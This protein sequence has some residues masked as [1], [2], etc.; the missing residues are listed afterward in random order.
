MTS[1]G[2]E[3]INVE[4]P[5]A[6]SELFRPHRYKVFYGGRGSAKSHSI[7]TALILQGYEQKLRILCAREYMMS[8]ADSVHRLLCDKIYELKLHNF[9]TITKTSIVGA[10]GTNFMFKGL[11]MSPQEIK[12]TEA[13]DRC[14]LEESQNVSNYSFEILI[15]TIRKENSEIWMSFNPNSIED[16]VYSRFVLNPPPDTY[17]RRVNF[18]ENPFFP[19]V[20]KKE[21]AHSQSTDLEA[22]SH[23]WL[24]E[25]RK[26]AE[27]VIFN[28]RIQ[29]REFTAPD[30]AR[31]YFGAD[32]GY[33]SDP[34]CIVRCFIDDAENDLYIDYESLAYG[35]EID[36]LYS[37]FTKVPGAKDWPIF[38]DC[39]RPETISYL[40][41]SGLAIKP[42][43]KWPGSIEDGL[44]HLKGYKN[45]FVHPRCKHTLEEFK[46][47]SY[48]VDT[49]TQE[50]LPI[51]IDKHNHIIDAL[52]YALCKEMQSRGSP[53]Q[54]TK[55]GNRL[56]PGGVA[57][58]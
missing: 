41:R 25:P 20:L 44:A 58:K 17:V 32:F 24:G 49:K 15:P 14:W 35:A 26:I 22:Y 31:Y 42:C 27:S 47:Y 52:R 54:W 39:A 33:S 10:N 56:N 3:I 1:A 9:Y 11:H 4:I 40:R 50:V 34:S 28:K 16:P 46:L 53:G 30:K 21:A 45:I 43:D 7:A 48:K 37:L 23:I 12:S 13:I 6:F 2:R 36:E 19:E 29:V 5:E 18:D 38:A 55:I 57:K 51:I 8:I